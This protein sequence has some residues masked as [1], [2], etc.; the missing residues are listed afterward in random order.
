[1][2]QTNTQTHQ[3]FASTLR[4]KKPLTV[5]Q[6]KPPLTRNKSKNKKVPNRSKSRGKIDSQKVKLAKKGF[7]NP[8]TGKEDQ[9]SLLDEIQSEMREIEKNR[10][11]D[12]QTLNLRIL[13]AKKDIEVMEAENVSFDFIYNLLNV[14]KKILRDDKLSKEIQ[15][16]NVKDLNAILKQL[17]KKQDQSDKLLSKAK[18]D[19]QKKTEDV[20]KQAEKQENLQ[21]EYDQYSQKLSTQG[22]QLF[23]NCC[24]KIAGGDAKD[25]E[26]KRCERRKEE[27][28]QR[29][30]G[31]RQKLLEKK[32]IREDLK[33]KLELISQEKFEVNK[34]VFLF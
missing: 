17:T 28:T 12:T 18:A 10:T 1:M 8:F 21:L 15:K 25:I 27:E 22:Q 24:E 20:K 7:V 3:D 9:I 16:R 30:D 29:Q 2:F 6:N 23:V 4:S 32:R 33:K 34:M 26:L 13:Q 11:I 5:T 19:V 31:L 14:K